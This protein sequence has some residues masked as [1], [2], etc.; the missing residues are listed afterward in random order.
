MAIGVLAG[1][2]F[3][4]IFA[5]VLCPI[6][7]SEESLKALGRALEGLEKLCEGAWQHGLYPISNEAACSET[8]LGPTG[9]V[10]TPTVLITNQFSLLDH[11]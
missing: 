5:L 2:I 4:A 7:A 10:P 11:L 8:S 9:C 3:T 6:S 1:I